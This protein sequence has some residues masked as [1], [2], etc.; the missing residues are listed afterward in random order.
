MSPGCVALCRY[1]TCDGLITR[2]GSATVCIKNRTGKQLKL[3]K[4][5][6]VQKYP[7]TKSCRN[8]CLW[9]HTLLQPRS[10]LRCVSYTVT[11]FKNFTWLFIFVFWVVT[12]SG[13]LRV[14][15]NSNQHFRGRYFVHTYGWR[16]QCVP[17]TLIYSFELWKQR[18]YVC[19]KRWHL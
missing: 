2:P 14:G 10:A 19:G 8:E 13:P 17:K 3:R 16:G 1:R 15:A 12:P 6:W 9:V 5:V 11:A 4:T 18:R 7:Y